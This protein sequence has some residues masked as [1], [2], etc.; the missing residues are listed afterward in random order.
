MP[1]KLA[2]IRSVTRSL[3]VE[4]AAGA[5]HIVYRLGE[6]TNPSITG[7]GS[8]IAMLAKWV[9]SWDLMDGE[10][11]YPLTEEAISALPLSF[12]LGTYEAIVKDVTTRP[13]K[14]VGSLGAG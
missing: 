10:E 11:V 9:A 2:D 1:I 4:T 5:V 6:V 14:K 13:T 7:W 3:E 8:Y 12:I